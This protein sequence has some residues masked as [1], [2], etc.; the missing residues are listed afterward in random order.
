MQ[1]A[2]DINEDVQ[3]KFE[4]ALQLTGEN[5]DNVVDALLKAYIAKSFSQVASSYQGIM[6][7]GNTNSNFAKAIHKIPKWAGKP[8]LMTSRIIRAYLLLKKEKEIVSY[9]DLMKR[10][11]DKENYPDE[12]VATFSNNF[13]QMKLDGEKTHGKV[14]EVNENGVVTLW[15]KVKETVM[16]NK[17]KFEGYSTA[18]GYVNK[19][20]QKNLGATG[21]KGSDIWRNLYNMRCEDCGHE[22]YAN[23]SDIHLKKCP[24]CQGGADTGNE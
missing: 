16:M 1:F 6:Q 8:K 2:A 3:R 19:N 9:S 23:G 4:M 12:Y 11:S 5:K 10:C 7:N 18:I 13:A 24:L 17:E 20:G 14:F 22:Y 21:E 15:E